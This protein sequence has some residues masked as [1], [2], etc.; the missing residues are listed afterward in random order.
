M[1]PESSQIIAG[2]NLI[3]MRVAEHNLPSVIEQFADSFSL[4]I[5]P[6]EQ[7]LRS[8]PIVLLTGLNKDTLKILKDRLVNLSKAGIEFMISTRLSPT[9]P[10]VVWPSKMPNYAVAPTGELIKY[11]DFQWRGNA[12]VCPNCAETF[13]FKRIG[14]PL[15][16]YLQV[17]EETPLKQTSTTTST[18]VKPKEPTPDMNESDVVE[19]PP[20]TDTKSGSDSDEVVELAPV[21][22]QSQNN[23]DVLEP[24]DILDG[25]KEAPATATQNGSEENGQIVEA[26]VAVE[27]PGTAP[28]P[29]ELCTCSVFLTSIP[30]EKKVATAELIAKMKGIPVKQAQILTTRLLVPILKDVTK[31]EATKCLLDFQK[32]GVKGKLTIKK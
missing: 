15:A 24:I 3:I 23:A 1:N 20:L 27:E 25:N 7:I 10:R 12:F 18:R 14:N 5:E 17:K 22:D 2:H 31:E 26:P 4:E 11:V 19:L 9:I 13:V 29:E 32:I 30:P 8:A 28:I 16:R 6:A 21:E